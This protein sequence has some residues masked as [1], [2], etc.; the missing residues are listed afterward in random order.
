MMWLYM[1]DFC[2]MKNYNIIINIVLVIMLVLI[3]MYE[4][5]NGLFYKKFIIIFV[6]DVFY[7]LSEII[8][9]YYRWK[10]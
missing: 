1:L 8:N 9:F 3:C 5:K 2:V 4:K 7:L 10:W 6:I